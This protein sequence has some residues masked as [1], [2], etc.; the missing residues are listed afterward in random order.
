MQLK[1]GKTA[2]RPE[3]VTFK[4]SR[5][6]TDLPK[7][8]R[9]FGHEKL[10]KDWGMLGNDRYGDCVIASKAH[11]SMIWCAEGETCANFSTDNVLSDY[12]AL[13]GFTKS[14]PATDNGTDMKLAASY[15]RTNGFLDAIGNRHKVLVYLSIDPGDWEQT[16]AAVWLF[17]AVEA[18]LRM[19]KSSVDQFNRGLPWYHVPNSPIDGMH[20]VPIIARRTMLKCVT[21]GRLQ[22]MTKRFYKENNDESIVYLSEEML[23]ADG[24]SI[25]GFNLEQLKE[26]LAKLV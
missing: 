26:D 8:P 24:V 23:G 19:P 18:G 21:W 13:T 2:P 11:M 5:Y 25:E 22:S 10:I 6:L 4:F 3:A 20:C 12:S 17:G 1:Y 7:Y 14:D 9:C 15:F 16:L